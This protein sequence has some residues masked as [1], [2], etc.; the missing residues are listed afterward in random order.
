LSDVSLNSVTTARNELIPG[1]PQF[2]NFD[3]FYSNNARQLQ[4]VARIVF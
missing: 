4:L 1:D 3:K 2:G